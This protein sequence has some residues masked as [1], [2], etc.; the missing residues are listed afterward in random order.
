MEIVYSTRIAA[1]A[2]KHTNAAKQ[3]SAWIL[4]A[5]KAQWSKSTDV[6]LDFPSAKIIQP[7]RARFEICG[8]S[9]RLVVAVDYADGII[10]VRFIGTHE[11]YDR[12]NATTI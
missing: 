6:L 7:D 1:F 3:L 4:K 9:Y 12:I 8:G 2:K 5:R 11:E 10:E